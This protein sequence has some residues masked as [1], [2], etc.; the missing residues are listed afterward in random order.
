MSALVRGIGLR[1]AIA[2]NMIT[3]IGIGPLITIPIVVGSLHGS[4]ALFAWVAGAFIA[5]CD[6]LVWA[7]LASRY[8]GSGGTY[9]YLREAFGRDR[10]GRFL[11]FL[12]NWQFLFSAPLLLAS[13]YIGFSQYAAY[14]APGLG[15]SLAAQ[16]LLAAALGCFVIFL[17]Y[18]RV[19]AVARLGA[20]LAVVAAL[21]LVVVIAA[22]LPHLHAS[23]FH[24]PAGSTFGAGFVAALGAALVITLYDYAGYNDAALVGDE[25]REPA[26]TIPRSILLSIGIVA[27]LYILLQVSVLSV[28]P[29][30][31]MLAEPGST[32]QYVASATIA[33]VWGA[34]PARIVTVLILVTALAS[35]YGLLLGFSRIPY[36]AALDDAF[37]PIFARLHPTGKFPAVAVL[38]VGLLALPACFVSLGAVIAFLTAGIVIIQAIAQIA[39][40]VLLRRRGPAPFRMWFYPVPAAIA[41]IAWLYIFYSS[42]NAAMLYGALTLGAGALAY[43]LTARV[44]RTWPFA[45]KALSVLALAAAGSLAPQAARAETLSPWSASAIVQQRGYPIFTVDRKPFFVYGAAFFYERIP[46]SQWRESLLAYKRMGINTIDLY[47]IWNWHELSD[48]NFDF[49]GRTNPRRD[50]VGLLRTIH[51]LGFKTIVRPGPVIRNEWR[52][53]G[54]PAWLLRRPE[55]AM[56]LRDI[57]EGRYPATATLQNARSDDAA[58]E[59]MNNKTH[60]A[61]AAR[62]LEHALRAIA[63]WRKD[64]IAIAVDDDQGAYIDNQ[65][66]PAPHFK[67][68]IGALSSMIRRVV[69]PHLPL[70]INTYQMKVTASAPV[71]AWGNWYQSDAYSIGEHDRSQLE[72]STALLQTQPHLPVMTSE[73]QAGWL[74]GA[75][76]AR[77][78]AADPTNTTLALHTML[79]FGAHGVVNFPVQDTLN[80]AGWEAPWTNAFYA[81]DAALSLQIG[82][83]ARFA[84]TA[85]FG[86]IVERHSVALAQLHP[87]ADVEIAYLTS[88]YDPA[89]LDNAQIAQIAA[90]TIAAQQAC[91][92]RALTCELVDLRYA[93]VADLLRTPVLVLPP[94]NSGTTFAPEVAQ[95]LALFSARGGWVGNSVTQAAARVAPALG[96]LRN[97]VL[98][99]DPSGTFGAV[100]IVNYDATA[101]S[102][103]TTT[104]RAFGRA[105][106]LT[107]GVVAP[108]SA[109]L[110]FFHSPAENSARAKAV[111]QVERQPLAHD[112]TAIPLRDDAFSATGHFRSVH[113]GQA[114]AYLDDAFSDGSPV[115]VF[116]NRVVRLLISSAAGARSLVFED[117]A[118][119]E[120]LFTS[121]G[122]LRDI[123]SQPLPPSARDYIAKYTHPLETGTFNRRYA[124]TVLSSGPLAA[125]HFLARVPDVPP[126]GATFERIV[127]MPPDAAAFSVDAKVTFGGNGVPPQQVGGQLSAF[128]VEASTHILT[129]SN[130]YGFY[131]PRKTRIVMLGW[132]AGEIVKRHVETRGESALVWL[133]FG[134]RGWYRMVYAVRSV[135]T[136]TAAH[137]VLA[138]FS[139]GIQGRDTGDANR[140]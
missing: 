40:L 39:A 116:E 62:W 97:A 11:A 26:R 107:S 13:G 47:V 102:F 33:E 49:T 58:A 50:L 4:L 96:G 21:T 35:T 76:E 31:R 98:L 140:R 123:W 53:G 92:A 29:W 71:W 105:E 2:V 85:A 122:A 115:V 135:A 5:A 64:V 52:N 125:A 80:P 18:R 90:A 43:F 114:L 65:T 27:L 69:G 57:L 109:R 3:M 70:F 126:A 79:Q 74:Q 37:F 95:K 6:G 112:A 117:K 20:A 15:Q 89:A 44:Q 136:A 99:V 137:A 28:I 56:P 108:R 36:A 1:G 19:H 55:Y 87:Q 17:L 61:Y 133:Y 83:Q 68:Y 54:Y 59:W 100:D 111:S 119:G 10:W 60:M 22:G 66:W 128:A 131:D 38:V 46:R 129:L 24:I 118:T 78:R 132:P 139:A 84:P 88:A 30:Q 86:R 82:T 73:F 101:M 113:P 75:D 103:P 91:R 16:H 48:G 34:W 104:F 41:L 25:V 45:L 106:R 120:N 81:W 124:A 93:A 63:P 32:A 51:A 12:F 130:V 8:P 72:F 77:P 9:V 42:G 94:N 121:V 67:Q 23:L 134:R 110:I 7:E 138:A 127:T 14:L